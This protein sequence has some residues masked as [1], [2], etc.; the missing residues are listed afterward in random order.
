MT[1]IHK[2]IYACKCNAILQLVVLDHFVVKSERWQSVLSESMDYSGDKNYLTGLT[3]NVFSRET[4]PSE[5]DYFSNILGSEW[6]NL[7]NVKLAELN[8]NERCAD[9]DE[10]P[11]VKG[12]TGNRNI[13]LSWRKEKIRE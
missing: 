2:H 3:P 8:A 1:K 6:C 13:L 5:F 12:N 4:C 7:E 10:N 11:V 9:C